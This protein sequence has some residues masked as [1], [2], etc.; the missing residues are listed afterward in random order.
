[1]GPK[2]VHFGPKLGPLG[3][4]AQWVV[5]KMAHFGPKS[6]ITIA[7]T[8]AAVV[9]KTTCRPV[10]RVEQRFPKLCLKAQFWSFGLKLATAWP[11][12]PR[13]DAQNCPF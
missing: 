1:M 5:P 12:G 13:S 3:R 11:C 2:M 9:P 4:K 8:G 7:P 6:I 10:L